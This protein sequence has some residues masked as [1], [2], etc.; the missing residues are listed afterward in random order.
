MAQDIRVWTGSAWESIKG[1]DGAPGPTVVSADA[2]NASRLGTDGRLFT[3]ATTV[4]AASTTAGLADTSAGTVGAS[5]NY[6]RADHT[7]PA[8]TTVF[9]QASRAITAADAGRIL[10]NNSG[11]TTGVT[12]TLPASTDTTVPIGTKIEI[13]D[14]SN[15]AATGVQA[16][17]GVLLR[18]N[19]SLVG[20]TRGTLGGGVAA[21]VRLP[22]VFARVILLKVGATAW[23]LLG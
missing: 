11:T 1:A 15:T 7:H 23:S 16:P 13:Y 6:A 5:A 20:G 22:D 14:A 9:V 8:V 2:G 19:A 10:V 21:G 3:P 12:F 4:P 18:Y 17:A